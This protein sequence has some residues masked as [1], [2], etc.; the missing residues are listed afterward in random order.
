MTFA[1][2]LGQNTTVRGFSNAW[3]VVWAGMVLC[4]RWLVP[5]RL[6]RVRRLVPRPQMTTGGL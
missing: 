4:R 6:L 3:V 2:I 1:E 5:A